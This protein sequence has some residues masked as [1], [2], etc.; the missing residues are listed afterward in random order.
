M[1][2]SLK[3]ARIEQRYE[4]GICAS[5]KELRPFKVSAADAVDK[6]LVISILDADNG[7]IQ[8]NY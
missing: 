4:Y 3:A 5:Y 1:I 7:M 6:G 8:M 2:S